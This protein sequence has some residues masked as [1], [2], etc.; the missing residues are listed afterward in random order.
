MGEYHGLLRLPE[1]ENGVEVSVDL[2]AERIVIRGGDVLIGDWPMDDVR[3]VATDEGFRLR[4][5]GEEVVL[6]V[7]RD[8][9]LAIELGLRSA[10]PVLRRRMAA[11]LRER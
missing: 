6:V 10:P 5:E 11:L 1:D 9:E 3:V 2:A 4:A 8:A 7:D